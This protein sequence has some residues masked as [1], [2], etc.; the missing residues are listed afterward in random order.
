M[1]HGQQQQG[2]IGPPCPVNLAGPP[3]GLTAREA[4]A[5]LAIIL[6]E[7]QISPRRQTDMLYQAIHS[8]AP[9][10]DSR[11][12][13]N[14]PESN[15]RG[16][17]KSESS[18]S[19]PASSLASLSPQMRYE[20]RAD[21]ITTLLKEMNLVASPKAS[22]FANAPKSQLAHRPDDDKDTEFVR[23][24]IKRW[25]NDESCPRNV[26]DTRQLIEDLTVQLHFL[27]TR[28]REH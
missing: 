24:Y 16:A 20:E 19:T 27:G 25:M 8:P 21:Q 9:G 11:L 18:G 14:F 6:G 1:A 23:Q 28:F 3:Q 5:D 7:K 2:L 26:E 15:V 10:T 22:I 13:N 4:K 17:P 12:P